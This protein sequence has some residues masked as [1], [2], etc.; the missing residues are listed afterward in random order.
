MTLNDTGEFT[1]LRPNNPTFKNDGNGKKYGI[2]DIEGILACA[3]RYNA[4]LE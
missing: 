4:L 2:F 1:L 3:R